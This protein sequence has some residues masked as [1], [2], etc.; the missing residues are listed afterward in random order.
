MNRIA[1]LLQEC[2]GQL[3]V[4]PSGNQAGD[5]LATYEYPS[6]NVHLRIFPDYPSKDEITLFLVDS[7]TRPFNRL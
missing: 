1:Q 5:F 7:L 4:A 3:T 6:G 2:G